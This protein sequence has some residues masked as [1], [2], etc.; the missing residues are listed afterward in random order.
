MVPFFWFLENV[1]TDLYF[2]L[3]TIDSK[4]L[5]VKLKVIKRDDS[6]DFHLVQDLV[7]GKTDLNQ[8]MRLRNQQ[9][10]PTENVAREKNLFTRL[11]PL[12]CKDMGEQLKLAHKL[13]GVVD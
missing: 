12:L 5:D 6:R 2:L 10:I 7:L 13:I 4:Y 1:Q 11:K 3:S 9:V 8:F